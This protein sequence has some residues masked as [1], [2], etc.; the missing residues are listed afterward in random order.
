MN[1]I[2]L[3]PTIRP[4]Q[5]RYMIITVLPIGKR[6]G[7]RNALKHRQVAGEEFVSGH[8]SAEGNATITKCRHRLWWYCTAFPI[9]QARMHVVKR[10]R[11]WLG[12]FWPDFMFHIHNQCE[13]FEACLTV[14]SQSPLSQRRMHFALYKA[15]LII[16][17][18]VG[19][20][21][22]KMGPPS[23]WRFLFLVQRLRVK[24]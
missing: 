15:V 2:T 14:C 8:G 17:F 6:S 24:I 20:R 16:A 5:S 7:R 22:S 9:T 12:N 1:G 3:Y 18:L 13:H 21:Y 10:S 19:N 11:V 4:Y 23:T